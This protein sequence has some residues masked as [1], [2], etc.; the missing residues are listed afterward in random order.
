M[1]LRKRNKRG[2]L[3]KYFF[4]FIIIVIIAIAAFFGVTFLEGEQPELTIQEN[5]Q[6]L[7]EKHIF[8]SVCQR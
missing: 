5:F 1:E 4:S 8:T 2:R 3:I 6:Y 7:G